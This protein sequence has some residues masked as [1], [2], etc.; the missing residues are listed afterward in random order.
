KLYRSAML[1]LRDVEDIAT[2]QPAGE[3]AST[4]TVLAVHELMTDIFDMAASYTDATKAPDDAAALRIAKHAVHAPL[5]VYE[6]DPASVR[7]DIVA[8]LSDE[9]IGGRLT[10]NAAKGLDLVIAIVSSGPEGDISAQI[11]A[12]FAPK[13]AYKVKYGR[14]QWT[15]GL[16]SLVGPGLAM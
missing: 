5:H 15:I 6:H 2:H 11:K 1:I 7:A 10:G 3:D 4:S 16:S 14:E 12:L 8:I 13:G 9:R